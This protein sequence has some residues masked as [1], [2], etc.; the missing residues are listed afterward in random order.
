MPGGGGTL[1]L[2]RKRGIRVLTK[3]QVFEELKSIV[4]P[5]IGIDIVNLGMVYGVEVSEDGKKVHIE[6]TLTTMGCPL[7]SQIERGI[8][9][10]VGRLGAE[11]V[12][13]Q[14]VWNPPWTPEF[15]SEEARQVLRYLF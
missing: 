5:E 9:M 4:D 12:D 2:R 10:Q 11:Q 8:E 14:L 3:E 6:M 1:K 7:Y 15:M 13:I